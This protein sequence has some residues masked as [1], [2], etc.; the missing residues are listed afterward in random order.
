[1]ATAR[2]AISVGASSGLGD[3]GPAMPSADLVVSSAGVTTADPDR[4]WAEG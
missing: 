2:G 3:A 4:E 1:M